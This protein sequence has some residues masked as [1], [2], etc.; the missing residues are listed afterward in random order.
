MPEH[1]NQPNLSFLSSLTP[2]RSEQQ[3]NVCSDR[4]EIHTAS[5]S[6]LNRKEALLLGPT[7]MRQ[8]LYTCMC[9]YV[10]SDSHLDQLLAIKHQRCQ[11]LSKHLAG[12]HLSSFT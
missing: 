3:F 12:N 1:D 11:G 2:L 7:L 5:D 10:C 6:V 8:A 4:L 9:V